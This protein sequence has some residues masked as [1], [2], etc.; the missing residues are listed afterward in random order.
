ML[1]HHC[2]QDD[3][4]RLSSLEQE[5][6][7]SSDGIS[8]IVRRNGSITSYGGLYPLLPLSLSLFPQL[9]RFSSKVTPIT[10]TTES[11]MDYDAGF[12]VSSSVQTWIIWSR[13]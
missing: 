6:F 11:G 2:P 3:P 12:V 8:A 5:A 13:P 4:S 10:T 9:T 7:L 1:K